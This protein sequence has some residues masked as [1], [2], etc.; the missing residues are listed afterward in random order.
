MTVIRKITLDDAPAIC[1]ISSQEM[2]YDCDLELVKR[3]IQRLDLTRE[4][5][6]V[7]EE[8]SQVLGFIHVERYEVLYF[9]SMANILGL[10]V[11][12]DFQKKG[13][14]KSLLLTAENWARENGISL[15][16]LNSGISRRN[17]HGFYEHL[18]YTSE[19]EQKRFL[20]KLE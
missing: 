1:E 3:K 16:R 9:E 15:M 2:G 13:L 19:K 11:R 5:V 17:A 6:F 10:A 7:A 12:K 14:G 8:E 4:A 18:G 20:K